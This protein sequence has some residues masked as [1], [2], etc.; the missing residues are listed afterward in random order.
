[1]P[2]SRHSVTRIYVAAQFVFSDT[3]NMLLRRSNIDKLERGLL[4]DNRSLK[5]KK[6]SVLVA[7]QDQA[8]NTNSVKKDI[9][10]ATATN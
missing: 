3:E 4:V 6:E 7:A 10:H 8:P 1:M 5:R 9:Y 2:N